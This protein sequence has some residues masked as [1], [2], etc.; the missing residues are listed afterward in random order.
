MEVRLYQGLIEL[1]WNLLFS[2]ITVVVLFLILK[3]FFF[4][5]VHNFMVERQ[6]AVEQQLENARVKEEEAESRL[7]EY[8]E[9]LNNADEE[10]REIIKKARSSAETQAAGIVSD[11]KKQA[12]DIIEKAREQAETE[13]EQAMRDMK[14]QVAEMAVMAA[15]RIIGREIDEKGQDDI[16]DRVI[17]EAGSTKW[18]K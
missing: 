5:K 13:T 2:F 6:H 14:N 1:N 15:G 10:G 16:I 4:E 12:A 8:N 3:H 17:E 9:T 11:A 7:A 18:Q